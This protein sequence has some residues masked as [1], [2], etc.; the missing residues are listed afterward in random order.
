MIL[1]QIDDQPDTPGLDSFA[2]QACT[3][4]HPPPENEIMITLYFRGCRF[5]QVILTTLCLH[6]AVMKMHIAAGPSIN[7]NLADNTYFFSKG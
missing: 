1:R 6:E 2:H 5:K 3:K 7:R 4:M